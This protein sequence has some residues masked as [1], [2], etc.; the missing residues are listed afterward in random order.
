MNLL[1]ILQGSCT[2]LHSC[3]QCSEK[4]PFYPHLHHHL[5]TLVFLIIAISTEVICYVPLIP[6]F[7]IMSDVD[8]FSMYL[9]AVGLSF[10]EKCLFRS[11]AHFLK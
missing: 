3:R 5:S 6:I 2:I 1:T 9:L 4:V 10:L 11:F 7:L 8:H